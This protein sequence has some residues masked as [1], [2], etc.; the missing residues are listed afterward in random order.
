V[1]M[2]VFSCGLGILKS[3]IY[4]TCHNILQCGSA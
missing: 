2:L 4:N 3:I 1:E